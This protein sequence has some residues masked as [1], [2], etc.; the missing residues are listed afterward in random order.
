[1]FCLRIWLTV[2][3][4]IAQWIILGRLIGHWNLSEILV[5]TLDLGGNPLSGQAF[6]RS[7]FGLFLFLFLFLFFGIEDFEHLSLTFYYFDF[8]YMF[9]V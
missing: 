8:A 2:R 1:M 4:L 7:D 5:M 3:N 9:L 6:S